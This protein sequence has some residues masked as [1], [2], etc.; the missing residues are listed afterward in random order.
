M[1]TP[2]T[3]NDLNFKPL[4][5]ECKNELFRTFLNQQT[6][7]DPTLPSVDHLGV[8]SPLGEGC[9]KGISFIRDPGEYESRCFGQFHPADSRSRNVIIKGKKTQTTVLKL[10]VAGCTLGFCLRDNYMDSCKRIY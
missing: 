8:G 4:Y 9:N 6:P 2:I 1:N 7:E 3:Q 5:L 10:C